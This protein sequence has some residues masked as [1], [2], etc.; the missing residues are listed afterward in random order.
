[1]KKVIYFQTKEVTLSTDADVIVDVDGERA[2]KLPLTFNILEKA[3][4]LI[5]K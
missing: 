1:M 4:K 3:I 5:I 2:Q